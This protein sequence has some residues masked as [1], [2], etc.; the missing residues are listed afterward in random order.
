[1]RVPGE[2][3]L[4]TKA[5]SPRFDF[6]RARKEKPLGPAHYLMLARRQH[7]DRAKFSLLGKRGSALR[8]AV[9]V[10]ESLAWSG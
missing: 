4:R 7:A 2:T 6:A 8:L 1:M 3:S 10:A 5:A 9:G